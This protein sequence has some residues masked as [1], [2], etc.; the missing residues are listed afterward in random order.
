[1]GPF[2]CPLKYISGSETLLQSPYSNSDTV[3]HAA[4]RP[5]EQNGISC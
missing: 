5:V 1:M 2:F 4:S 3:G